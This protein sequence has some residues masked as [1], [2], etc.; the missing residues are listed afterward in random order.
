VKVTLS[1]IRA[2]E[3]TVE[4]PEKCPHCDQD[5]HEPGALLEEQYIGATQPCRM[6]GTGDEAILDDY[7]SGDDFPESQF[8]MGFSC[9]G[10]AKP[11]VS[12]ETP[13]CQHNAGTRGG[14]CELCGKEM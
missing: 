12:T 3:I 7:A 10:C 2:E 13:F 14:V 1:K 9:R 5:F 8:V 11:V 6:S 4:L